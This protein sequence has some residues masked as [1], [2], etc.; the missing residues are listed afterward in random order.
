MELR[1]EY[2]KNIALQVQRWDHN[3]KH[4][5]KEGQATESQ[6][7]RSTLL[8]FT[9]T[10]LP[11]WNATWL[12]VVFPEVAW[13]GEQELARVR[14]ELTACGHH[15]GPHLTECCQCLQLVVVIV[16]ED[17]TGQQAYI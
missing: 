2:P 3:L 14:E 13:H 17:S 7:N 12:L 6:D 11:R 16:D 1:G 9:H 4:V 5:E 10:W 8:K 15:L